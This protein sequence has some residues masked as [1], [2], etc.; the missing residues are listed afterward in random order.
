MKNKYLKKCSKRI[1]QTRQNGKII[2]EETKCKEKK[3][4]FKKI[5]LICDS[6]DN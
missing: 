3:K 2:P 1:K 4:T 6:G 5:N